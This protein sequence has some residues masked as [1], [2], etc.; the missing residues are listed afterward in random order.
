MEYQGEMLCS[1]YSHKMKPCDRIK[2]CDLCVGLNVDANGNEMYICGLGVADFKCKRDNPGCKPLTKEQFIELY[3]QMPNKTDVSVGEL[4]EK[5]I[6][7]G[8]VKE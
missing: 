1:G 6:I 3:K 2:E 4:L 5:A 8:I 7:D